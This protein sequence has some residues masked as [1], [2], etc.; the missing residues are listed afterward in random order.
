MRSHLIV[1]ITLFCIGRSFPN[2]HGYQ[3]VVETRFQGEVLQSDPVDHV[4]QPIINTELAW[5]LSKKSL[6]QHRLQ[7]TPI[8]LQVALLFGHTHFILYAH[9]CMPS[10][11]TIVTHSKVIP[12][13]TLCW[14]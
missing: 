4:I 14:T 3:L 1:V 12:L 13:V 10:A 11:V 7:R 5:S 2:R 6:H 8:K 9:S